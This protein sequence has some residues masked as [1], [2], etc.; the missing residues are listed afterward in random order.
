MRRWTILSRIESNRIE[1]NRIELIWLCSML[2]HKGTW[3]RHRRFSRRFY[4]VSSVGSVFFLSQCIAMINERVIIGRFDLFA[5]RSIR[6]TYGWAER[7]LLSFSPASFERG[8]VATM[9]RIIREEPRKVDRT[10]DPLHNDR[11]NVAER[12]TFK[13]CRRQRYSDPD[14]RVI[15]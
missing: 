5:V 15:K 7:R 4:D 6:Y 13:R 11:R 12:V 9:Q 2:G 3:K 8:R 1:S 10:C 14:Y